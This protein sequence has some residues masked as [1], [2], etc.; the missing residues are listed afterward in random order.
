MNTAYDLKE[1]SLLIEKLLRLTHAN[2]IEWD[3]NHIFSQPVIARFQTI[4]DGELLAQIW[5]SNKAAGFRLVEKSKAPGYGGALGSNVP[6]ESAP[7]LISSDRDLVAISI[8]HESGAAQGEIYVNLMSL[9]ELARISID[10][11]EPK[12]D[13]V[14]QYLD[15]LAV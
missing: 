2:K 7:F 10:K 15:K 12:I 4:L 11:V 1:S 5:S 8:N 3:D 6:V 13:R 14:K 9:L